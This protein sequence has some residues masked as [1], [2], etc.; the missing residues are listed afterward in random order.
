MSII[1]GYFEYNVYKVSEVSI[2]SL[3]LILLYVFL[4]GFCNYS[5]E[6]NN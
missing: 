3:C 4:D 5:Y 2:E 1:R 6:E